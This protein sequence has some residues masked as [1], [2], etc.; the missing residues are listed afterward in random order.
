MKKNKLFAVLVSILMFATVFMSGCAFF[1]GANKLEL[2]EMPKST[3]TL[4][5]NWEATEESL[6]AAGFAFAIKLTKDNV[7][8]TYVFGKTAG[9]GEKQLTYDNGFKVDGV[10]IFD[11]VDF[12]LKKAGKYTAKIKGEGAICTFVY[13]VK[14]LSANDGFARGSGVEGDPYIIE[15]ANQLKLLDSTTNNNLSFDS[16]VYAKLANDINMS[17]LALSTEPYYT[18]NGAYDA[19]TYLGVMKNVELDGNGHKLT[20]ISE[21][22]EYVIMTTTKHVVIKNLDLYYST[23]Y[24]LIG[25]HLNIA[26]GSVADN[27]ALLFKNIRTYGSISQD[28]HNYALYVTYSYP[29]VIFEDC[30]NRCNIDGVSQ[31]LAVFSAMPYGKLKF[32][33]CENYG[34]IAGA[35]VAVFACNPYQ[36]K[37]ITLINSANYAKLYAANSANVVF[38]T[39]QY[40]DADIM[41][42]LKEGFTADNATVTK[43]NECVS[44][45]KLNVLPKGNFVSGVAD[46]DAK[47]KFTVGSDKVAKVVVTA[48]YYLQ[49]MTAAEG[50]EQAGTSLQ[51]IKEEYTTADFTLNTAKECNAIGKLAVKKVA[52]TEDETK[53]ANNNNK[54]WGVHTDAD[55]KLYYEVMTMTQGNLFV[56]TKGGERVS[57]VTLFAYDAN[58]KLLAIVTL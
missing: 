32:V 15:D 5:Q 24:C 42:G 1:K 14:D 20:N 40:K 19:S 6:T 11:L 55:G 38:A 4:T 3:Y 56:T 36:V 12:N 34:E 46:K 52:T 58:G 33:N 50:G 22:A 28:S 9:E 35:H 17:T 10:K 27:E 48:S 29:E 39:D 43:Y 45:G 13:T 31:R 30:I 25:E 44:D 16:V 54:V 23:P 53:L 49:V 8:T 41:A 47:A 21:N 37:G 51:F 57:T 18:W 26:A 7:A 2:T